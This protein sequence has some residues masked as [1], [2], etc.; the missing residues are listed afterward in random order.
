MTFHRTRIILISTVGAFLVVIFL[1]F[2]NRKSNRQRETQLLAQIDALGRSNYRLEESVKT[3][4]TDID[5]LCKDFR[6]QSRPCARYLPLLSEM[7]ALQEQRQQQFK[8][9]RDRLDFQANN[10]DIITAAYSMVDSYLEFFEHFP[11]AKIGVALKASN[12]LA[13]PYE[14]RAHFIKAFGT[15]DSL[16]LRYLLSLLENYLIDIEW[17]FF[18]EIRKYFGTASIEFTKFSPLFIFN[19]SDRTYRTGETI[20]ITIT[21]SKVG[22]E[23]VIINGKQI[24]R[25]QENVFQYK[26]IA[27]GPGNKTL[28]TTFTLLDPLT[29]DKK[30]ISANQS[31][32]VIK[33]SGNMP[34]SSDSLL[35]EEEL[36]RSANLTYSYPKTIKRRQS[37]SINV[38]LSVNNP[39][40]TLEEVMKETILS[41]LQVVEVSD[42]TNIFSEKIRFYKK[43]SVQLL[44]PEKKF[45]ITP[46]HDNDEQNVDTLIGNKWRWNI[47]TETD[48][49]TASLILKIRAEGPNDVLK[50]K[51]IFMTVEI[52]DANFFRRLWIYLK[53]NPAIFFSA[54]I[55]PL[56]AFFAKKGYE[57]WMSVKASVNNRPVSKS[58]RKKK[59]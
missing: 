27:G 37:K 9:L 48:R 24:T 13:P 38:L 47:F 22:F 55:I 52:G 5:R 8:L 57:R 18:Q 43:L 7:N 30:E 42:T 12:K 31:Y 29:G 36:A 41:Q 23:S 10:L 45:I 32:R 14:S 35:S 44:D 4:H 39:S 49:P 33:N 17:D 19:R 59:S 54:I 56:L 11:E 3:L 51:T 21:A 16:E 6:A 20:E 58:K 40:G 15:N 46:V 34:I 28:H 1:V 25:I 53:E 2:S 50:D 26:A